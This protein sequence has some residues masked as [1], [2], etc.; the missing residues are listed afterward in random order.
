MFKYAEAI[1]TQRPFMYTQ[2]ELTHLRLGHL[3]LEK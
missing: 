1:A 3:R 2:D